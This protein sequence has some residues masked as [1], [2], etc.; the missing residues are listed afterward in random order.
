MKFRTAYSP[1]LRVSTSF[2]D[3]DGN[4]LPSLTQQHL[5]PEV[6]INNIIAKYNR[7][8]VIEHVNNAV[9][10]YGDFSAVNEYQESLNMVIR[11]QE[12]FAALPSHIRKLFDH[13]PG[14]FFEFATD[15]ENASEMISLGLAAPPPEVE[16]KAVVKPTDAPEQPQDK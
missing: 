10:E 9:A 3:G 2:L 14:Q 4:P 11:A 12:S 1:H 7:Q 8:G 16:E 13:D 6:D 15:P 5:K